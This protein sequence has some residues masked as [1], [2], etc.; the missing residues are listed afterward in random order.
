MR[1]S[2]IGKRL[3]GI[4]SCKVL[5]DDETLDLYSVDASAYILKPSAVAFPR[6]ERD[7]LEILKYASQ[8]KIPVTA[9]GAGTGLVGGALGRGIILDMRN[10]DFIRI[11][12]D[13]VGVGSGTFKGKLDEELKKYGRFLGPD[14][15][16]GPFCTIGGMIAT[17]ASGSHSLKYG[18]I[19]DNLVQVRIITSD[20]KLLTLPNRDDITKKICRL[21]KPRIQKSFPHVSKNSCGYRI[22]KINSEKDIQKIIPASEGTLGIIVSAKLKT[23]PIPKKRVLIT[24]S[25]R[26]L[27]QAFIDVPKIV[28]LRPSALEVIDDNIARHAKNKIPKGIKCVLFAEFDENTEKN[29]TRIRKLTSGAIIREITKRDEISKWW[30]I[31][32]SA[33]SYSLASISK[34][35][36]MPSLIEDATVPVGKLHL[37][38]DMVE[39]LVSKYDMRAVIYGHAGNGNLH[40]RPILRNKDKHLM[41]EIAREFFSGVVRLGGSITGEHGDGLARS[42]F[43]KLQ[44]GDKIYSVFKRIKHIFDPTNTLNP[45]KIISRGST[46]TKYLKI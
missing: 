41:E 34:H 42:E 9:R 1:D 39:D 36:T 4:V 33:L 45:G 19:I 38:L 11:G 17:N 7:I 16:I 35:D 43:V 27:K 13:N 23:F 30:S 14:P 8:H 37:L 6:N 12:S 15:S 40:I 25:Y 46:V 10:F 28:K 26:T 5:W 31:R 32:N 29:R 24:L 20:G 18:S 22:D 3:S 44:Y 2:R 21:I